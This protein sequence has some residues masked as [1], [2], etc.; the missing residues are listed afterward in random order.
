[1]LADARE[2]YV[3]SGDDAKRLI[4]PDGIGADIRVLVQGRGMGPEDWRFQNKLF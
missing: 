1:M 4:L 2:A 3:I